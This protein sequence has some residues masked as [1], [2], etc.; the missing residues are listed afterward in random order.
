MRIHCRWKPF[1]EQLPSDSPGIIDVF[2]VRYQA[3][4]VPSRDR[5]IATTIHATILTTIGVIKEGF[6]LYQFVIRGGLI[7]IEQMEGI[8]CGFSHDT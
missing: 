4:H 3:P 1:T 5:C 7:Y 6:L 2:T 8:C